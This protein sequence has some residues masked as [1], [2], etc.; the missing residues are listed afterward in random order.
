MRLRLR[1]GLFPV[2]V[3][4]LG[5]MLQI[6]WAQAPQGFVSLFNGKDLTGW[7]IPKGDNGHWKVVDGVIDNALL[8]GLPEKGPVGLQHHGG[9]ADGKYLGPPSLVQ[10]RNIYIK[11]IP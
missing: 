6:S 10:F 1:S 7:K 5:I 3:A 11:E 4:S 8:P 9:F 2:L